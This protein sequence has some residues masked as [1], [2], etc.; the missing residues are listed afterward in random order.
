MSPRLL[1]LSQP[2][3]LMTATDVPESLSIGGDGIALSNTTPYGSLSTYL[4]GA[5]TGTARGAWKN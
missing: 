5:L 4:R 2:H 1:N 3:E